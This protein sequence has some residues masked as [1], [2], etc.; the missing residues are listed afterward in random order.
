MR[1]KPEVRVG[2]SIS[3]TGRFRPQGQQALQGIRL[4]QSYINAQGGISVRKGAKR[5][6]RLIWHDDHSQ[7]SAARTNVLK[8]LHEDQV[9]ILF[10][11]YSSSL[12]MAVA[13]TAEEHEKVLWNHGG[14]SDDIFRHGWRYLVGIAS[15][16]SHYLRALPRWLA[17]AHPDLARICVLYAG[18]G[19]FGWQV[20]RGVLEGALGVARHSVHLVPV[21]VPWEHD[22]T[23]HGVLFGIAPEVVVLA[24]SFEDELSIMRTRHRWPNT[25][26]AVAAVAAGVRAFSVELGRTADEVFGPSQ[27]EPTVTLPDIVGPTSDWFLETFQRQFAD[28]PDYIAA[29]SFATGLIL[30]ECIRRSTSL[31]DGELRNAACELDCNTFY[32]RFRIDSRTGMQ[33]GHRV[34]LVRWEEGR[35]VV[36]SPSFE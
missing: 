3:L 5:S 30:T 20:A 29:G 31:H 19:T 9:D 28:A 23:V 35:R 22:N 8:L 34:V 36:L 2:L 4:W 33:M 27:W 25:V 10:G 16:A 18:G 21:N 26:R 6:V 15:P 14:S 12:T 17:E 24:G 1:S 32:G 11:P 7:I 13:E